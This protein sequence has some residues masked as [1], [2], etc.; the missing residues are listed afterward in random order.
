MV[1]YLPQD[2]YFREA[3]RLGYVARS[4]FKLL[5]IQQKHKVV[6]R[7]GAVLDLG[8]CPGAW[9]QVSCQALSSAKYGGRV[10]GVDLQAVAKRLPFCDDRV[11]TIRADAFDITAA[12]LLRISPNGFNAVLSDM[13]PSTS[14]ASSADVARSLRLAAIAFQLAVG[15]QKGLP[16]DGDKVG[17]RPGGG[18]NAA[19]TTSVGLNDRDVFSNKAIRFNNRGGFDKRGG[20][21]DRAGFD[22][23]G[24]SDKRAGCDDRGSSADTAKGSCREFD[25]EV[26]EGE[27]HDDECSSDRGVLVRK[28]HMVIKLLEG[29]G[30]REF[31]RLCRGVFDSITWVGPAATRSAS[32]EVYLV[33]KGRKWLRLVAMSL[34]VGLSGFDKQ[35]YV[36]ALKSLL[37]DPLLQDVSKKPSLKEV[38]TLIAMELGNA[39]RLTINRLDGT[40][41]EVMVLD[42]ATVGDLKMAIEKAFRDNKTLSSRQCRISWRYLWGHFCLSADGQRLLDDKAPLHRFGITNMAVLQFAHH[43]SGKGGGKHS[44][45]RKRRFFR[46]GIGEK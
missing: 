20:F 31:G 13:C 17:A 26:L 42:N 1:G 24:G 43:I 23:R 44:R 15:S 8:C 12:H 19:D 45:P 3:K 25:S 28:G 29:S 46:V 9:L 39:M 7:G 36:P 10:L 41:F 5:E 40:S 35:Q 18:G 6:P 11:Q 30:T 2:F 22:Y 34:S 4:A 32:R 37:E 21:D 27:F 16:I 38:E 33:A 14:G